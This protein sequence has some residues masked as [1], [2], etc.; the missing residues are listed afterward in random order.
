MAMLNNQ[1]VSILH[2]SSTDLKFGSSTRVFGE[3]IS[4]LKNLCFGGFSP[5]DFSFQPSNYE[6]MRPSIVCT[7]WGSAARIARHSGQG[8]DQSDGFMIPG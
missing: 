2:Q 7:N 1:R 8:C 5:V 6:A 4:V 3:L